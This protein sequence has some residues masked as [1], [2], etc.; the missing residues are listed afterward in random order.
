MK[1][2][3]IA[4]LLALLV[5]RG[6]AQSPEWQLLA[7]VAVDGLGLVSM[8]NRDNVFYSD[9][10]GNV[11]KMDES[12]AVVNHYSPVFQGRLDHL[13]AF[14]T[15]T[16]FLFSA[17]LQ[18]AVLLD[19]HLAPL[20]SFS[21][22][23]NPWI[24]K[25]AA[26]GNNNTFWLLDEVDFT[27]K[28][29]DYRLGEVL[30]NQPLSGILEPGPI[31]VAEIMER[32]NLV[33][34]H[35]RNQ[36]IYVFDNQGNFIQKHAVLLDQKPA[37]YDGHLYFIKDSLIHQLNLYSGDEAVYLKPGIPAESL[38]VGAKKM[39]FYSNGSLFIFQRP[40]L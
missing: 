37:I 38:L 20:N 27:L 35:V 40:H 15:M 4:C 2:I 23:Q 26:P 6:Y 28:K 7:E 33:F 30:Q 17:D 18:Q 1:T 11:Y 36:G 13:D 39:V 3:T 16:L 24:I 9:R 21:F 19:S 14:Y 22:Q 12:G 29:Y 10:E 5:G 32:Q 31:E 34:M 8:D 25:A